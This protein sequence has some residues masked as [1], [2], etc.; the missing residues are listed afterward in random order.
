MRVELL[1]TDA[2]PMAMAVRQRLIE[3]LLEDAYETPVQMVV[4]NS[5]EDAEFL[6]FPGSPT[7]RIDGEDLDPAGVGPVGIGPRSY[8]GE[9]LPSADL[10]RSAIDRAR[11]WSHSRK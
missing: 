2:D 3:V 8:G 9:P 6:G 11:G 4:V 5:I 10:I 1:Y 7:I